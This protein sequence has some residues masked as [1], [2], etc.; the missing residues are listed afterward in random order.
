MMDSMIYIIV[1]VLCGVCYYVMMKNSIREPYKNCSFVA[2]KL[3]DG[4]AF[5]VGAIL[6]YYG[7]YKYEDNILI[8]LGI[9][10]ITEHILQFS[11]KLY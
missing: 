8:L 10:I 5:V 11:Y 3:T 7:Y 6:I 9:A 4:L 2:N 1:G